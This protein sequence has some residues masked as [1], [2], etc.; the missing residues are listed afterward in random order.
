[1]KVSVKTTGLGLALVW[2]LTACGGGEKAAS[3]GEIAL[4]K[5]ADMAKATLQQKADALARQA[6][7]SPPPPVEKRK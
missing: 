7:M 6:S 3:D 5:Q 4:Q 1:M 2:A